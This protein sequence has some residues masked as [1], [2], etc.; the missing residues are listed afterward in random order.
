M[1]NAFIHESVMTRETLAYL[2]PRSGGVYADAT[3]GG[4]GHTAA[5]LDASAPDG[6]VL[7]VDR[8]P[9]AIEHAQKRLSAYGDR[10]SVLHGEFA[11][12]A[13]LLEGAGVSRVDGVVADLGVSSPQLDVAE[14]GFSFQHVGPLDMRMDTSRGETVAQLIARLSESELAD[15]IFHFGEERRS[16]AIARS[17]R[18]MHDAGELHTTEDL[19]MAVQ[20]AVGRPPGSKIDPATRTFQALRIACNRELDQL[21]SL[22]GALPDVLNDGGVAVLISFHSLEDRIVKHTLR[23][24]DVLEVLTKKPVIAADDEQEKNRRSRS[25]KLRAA[26]RVSRAEV[27]A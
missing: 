27:Q 10:V 12:L 18:R 23:D 26:V 25:A 9:R 7:A 13:A 21:R 4:G 8:D 15:V 22:L 17:I 14:R 16:R 20:R 2:K 24:S 5:I 3:L 11:D 1:E 6:R 19:R